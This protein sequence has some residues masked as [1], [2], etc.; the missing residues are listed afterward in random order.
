MVEL[1][2]YFPVTT[3][4]HSHSTYSDESPLDTLHNPRL[5]S[6]E[7]AFVVQKCILYLGVTQII[8]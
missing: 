8:S 7:P 4:L 1:A 5:K 6:I 2:V 3:V